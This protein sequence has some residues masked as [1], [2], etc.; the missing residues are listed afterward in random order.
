VSSKG[1]PFVAGSKKERLAARRKRLP[2]ILK[3]VK[4][5]SRMTTLL[6]VHNVPYFKKL[7]KPL[8]NLVPEAKISIGDGVI[9]ATEMD[10]ANVAMIIYKVRNN[11]GISIRSLKSSKIGLDTK[12]FYDAIKDIKKDNTLRVD[13]QGDN[14]VLV[15]PSKLSN[16]D[17]T[18]KPNDLMTMKIPLVDFEK[19]DQKVPELKPTHSILLQGDRFLDALKEIKKH[20]EVLI[21]KSSAEGVVFSGEG[22]VSSN[23]ITVD[24]TKMVDSEVKYSVEY[25]MQLAPMLNKNTLIRLKWGTDYPLVATI[26]SQNVDIK[27]ILAPRIERE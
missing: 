4:K 24:S 3:D 6:V 15:V 2:G 8:V 22:N 5:A 11:N 12:L 23:K 14:L 18:P 25:L 13:L 7:M 21:I 17:I 10:P 27:F 19:K 9:A 20:S 16:T 26:E 1:K